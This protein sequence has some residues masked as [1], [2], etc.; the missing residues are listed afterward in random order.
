MNNI[1]EGNYKGIRKKYFQIILALII[2]F[3]VIAAGLIIYIYNSQNELQEESEVIINKTEAI[4]E[5]EKTLNEIL[6]RA[7]GYYAFQSE[8]ELEQLYI[9]LDRLKS[10][11]NNFEEFS[12]SDEELELKNDVEYFYDNYTNNLLPLAISYVEQND[13]ESLRELSNNGNNSNINDFLQYTEKFKE[14]S[15]NRYDDITNQIINQSNKYKI[16]MFLFSTLIL[17]TFLIIIAYILKGIVYPIEKL[18][19][20]N[21]KLINGK[22]VELRLSNRKDEIGILENSFVEMTKIVQ[23]KEEELILQNEKLLSQQN[24]SK[25]QQQ[26]LQQYLIEIESMT[27]ALDQSTNVCITDNNG[28]IIEV[29]DNFCKSTQYKKEDLIGK[30]PRILKSGEHTSQFFKNMWTDISSG[31]VWKGEIKNLKKDGS[32]LWFNATIVPYT[33]VK[34][35]SYKY[36]LIGVDITKTK[37]TQKQ[38]ITSLNETDIIRERLE[39]YN[40]FNH[41]LTY[42]LNKLKFLDLVFN[43]LNTSFDFD[44]S[45]IWLQK[46]KSYFFKGLSKDKASEI[47]QDN[48]DYIIPRL[49]EDKYFYIKRKSN[50]DE[51]GIAE[52]EFYCYDYYFAIFDAGN[53]V[54]AVFAATKIE[55]VLEGDEIEEI[56]GLMKQLSLA[57]GRIVLYEESQRDRELN[58][59]II[60]NV[61]EGI[62]FVSPEGEIIQYNNALQDL[63]ELS[64]FEDDSMKI[65]ENWIE[66]FTKDS[67]EKDELDKFFRQ[68]IN[69]KTNSKKTIYYSVLRDDERFIE[70]YAINVFDNEEKTGTIFVYRDITREH[71]IDQMKTD[72]VSTVSHELRTPLSS[73]LGFT[74]LLLKKDQKPDRQR[75]YLEIIYKESTRL[76]NLINDFLDL[77]RMESGK[78]KYKLEY[79]N[80]NEIIMDVIL[81]FKNKENYNISLIDNSKNTEVHMDKDRIIQVL[82]NLIS[83]GIKFSPE[84]G[85]II[86]SLDNYKD[87]LKVMVKDKGIGIPEQEIPI[88]FQK[89]KRVDNSST[90]DVGGTGLGLAICKEIIEWHE[91]NIWID[92]KEGEGTEVHF[93]LPLYDNNSNDIDENFTKINSINKPNIMIVEDDIS[94]SLLLSEEL[95]E[96]GFT[97]INHYNPKKAFEEALN[98]PLAGMVVDLMFEEEMKGWDLIKK[99]KENKS[100]KNIPIIISS[101]L[102]KQIENIQ[103]YEIQ[104]YLV[105]PYPSSEL[106]KVISKFLKTHKDSG[107]IMYPK[108]N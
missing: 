49:K 87:K 106:S 25:E 105:K 83:N 84:G 75:K 72:L 61:N 85:D 22:K 35:I 62:Q 74:E 69:S 103:K 36:I 19:E 39:G 28:L 100:T 65:K 32:N 107:S 46:E 5:I 67:K 66:F 24:K 15:Q 16:Y 58:Q 3:I 79:L 94:L 89:F 44:K 90:S 51:I 48:I 101:A 45:I 88:L 47:M 10:K 17:L 98:T 108:D 91:G 68:M 18:S 52:E 63:M 78:Q 7:R 93:T 95:K 21:K 64:N 37:E 12:L 41:S 92:S 2:F 11:L 27:Q 38:L 33:D 43:Y 82:N 9:N 76:T 96:K 102:E 30:T 42:T 40:Q 1:F 53:D 55:S 97:V 34:G 70:L 59:N 20:A 6:F 99:L 56:N 31:K 8:F 26:V 81:S 86:I 23:E 29:N 73:I 50:S 14:E 104:E 77:Q 80:M 71:E 57:F 13:Y 60:D 54:E 4:E